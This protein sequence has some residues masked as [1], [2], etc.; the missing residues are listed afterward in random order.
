MTREQTP[1]GQKMSGME[2]AVDPLRSGSCRSPGTMNLNHILKSGHSPCRS[3]G[4]NICHG[5]IVLLIIQEPAVDASNKEF[6]ETPQKAH[7]KRDSWLNLSNRICRS[8]NVKL[9]ECSQAQ[10]HA[11]H[12]L[13]VI[14]F[15]CPR[16]EAGGFS[17][18]ESATKLAA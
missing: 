1:L 18:I 17:R 3:Y 16:L 10:G 13:K 8:A 2:K 15:A 11:R 9:V 4:A 7:C 14:A 5:P 12:I 6:H